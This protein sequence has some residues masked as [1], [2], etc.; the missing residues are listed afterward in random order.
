MPSNDQAQDARLLADRAITDEM[1]VFFD[2]DGTLTDSS[3][4]MRN[5][6]HHALR[7]LDRELPPDERIRRCFGPPLAAAFEL[8]LQTTDA[9]LIET[10][11]AAYRSRYST[12]GLLENEPYPGIVEGLRTL[13][14]E[15]HRLRIVTAKPEPFAVRIT[16]HFQLAEFFDAVHAPTL[17]DRTRGKLDSLRAAVDAIA[18]AP[19]DIVM[20]GDL[21]DDVYAARMC[22]VKSIAAAW[23]FGDENALAEA[24][25]ELVAYTM[26]E[27]VQWVRNRTRSDRS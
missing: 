19:D 14:A 11:I 1:H 4:G 18:G 26:A 20:V 25:P 6:F 16:H 21:V 8:L 13:R 7:S 17:A 22:G 5:S 23:G 12:I 24:G 15:G 27:V 10:A 3:A 2:L 9:D